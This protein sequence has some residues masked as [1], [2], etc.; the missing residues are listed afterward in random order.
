MPIP[1]SIVRFSI[2]PIVG[3][4]LV[5]PLALAMLVLLFVGPDRDRA[6]RG[7]RAVLTVLRLLVILLVVFGM[8]RPTLVWTKITKQAA[9]LLV[10]VDHSRSMLVTDMVGKKSRWEAA[11]TA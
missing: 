10:L 9:T 7:R 8:L 6:S 3:W 11:E 5:V 1:T 2:A 4:W